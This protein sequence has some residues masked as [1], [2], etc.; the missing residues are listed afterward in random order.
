[1]QSQRERLLFQL[2][3][4]HHLIQADSYAENG[5]L[6]IVDAVKALNLQYTIFK[7]RPFESVITAIENELPGTGNPVMLWGTTTIERA[8]KHYGWTPG[9]FKNSNFD[10]R[11]LGEKYG[12][13]MLNSACKFYRLGDVPDFEGTIFIR[14]VHDTKSFT[15]QLIDDF[16]FQKWKESLTELKQEFTTLDL[17]TVVMVAGIKLI[18]NEARFFVVNGKVISGSTYRVNGQLIKKRI[19]THNPLYLPLQ[20][21]AQQVVDKWNPCKAFV[22]DIGEIEEGFRVIEINCL[23]SS[24]FYDTDMTAVVRA[25]EHLQ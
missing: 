16:E 18:R 1:M 17:D 21:F 3:V 4:M 2:A 14:P 8:A 7:L 11:V 25:I 12:S 5:F 22:I 24:G 10:M 23:N 20:E 13:M 15:G 6:S 9:V 19:G